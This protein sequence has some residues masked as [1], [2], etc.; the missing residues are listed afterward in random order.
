MRN[1]YFSTVFY[2]SLGGQIGE[3]EPLLYLSLDSET[4]SLDSD[5]LGVDSEI[6]GKVSWTTKCQFLLSS[7]SK[8][9]PFT[10]ILISWKLITE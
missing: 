3:G 10:E 6:L 4:L 9:T 7:L 1:F 5:T 2:L 8:Q